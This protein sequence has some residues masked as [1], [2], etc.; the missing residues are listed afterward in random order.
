MRVA[1]APKCVSRSLSSYLSRTKRG[2]RRLEVYDA[3]DGVEV[4]VYARFM[5]T[6]ILVARGNQGEFMPTHQAMPHASTINTLDTC[7]QDTA[8]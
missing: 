3:N 8:T 7:A 1:H 6:K 2:V 5:E 4:G